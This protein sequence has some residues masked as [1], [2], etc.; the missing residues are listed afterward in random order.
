MPIRDFKAQA[1]QAR[2]NCL[3][4]LND[5]NRAYLLSFDKAY[6]VTEARKA[7]FYRH[8]PHF[9]ANVEDAKKAMQNAEEINALFHKLRSTL[10]T[11]YYATIINVTKRFVRWLNDGEL[12]NGFKQ[13][14]SV[15]KKKL[16]RQLTREDMIEWADGEAMANATASVQLKAILLTQLEGGFRPS[17]FIDLNYGDIKHEDDLL[18]AHVRAGKTGGRD[19]LLFKSAKLLTAWLN[20]HPTKKANDPLWIVENMDK[21]H[22]KDMD[23]NPYGIRRYR[24]EALKK[25]IKHL[26]KKAGIRKPLDFYNFRHSA[27]F[28]AKC[29]NMPV[30][31]AATNFGH[32]AQYFVETYGRLDVNDRLNRKRKHLGITP[33]KA[34]EKPKRVCYRCKYI[35]Q[36]DMDA[37][38][39]CDAPLSFNRAVTEEKK[40][41]EEMRLVAREL[42]EEM[43]QSF[44]KGR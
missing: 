43:R 30:D 40:R 32:S 10:G 6:D 22:R 14:R 21:S 4:K 26:A 12:P 44:E 33:K 18:V 28:L 16:K 1:E 17:E 23:D 25:R 15:P 38:A 31:E 7:I 41:R 8:I 3:G 20:A 2:E 11:A 42:L 5:T 19:V 35:N 39:Q 9:L 27:C 34:K 37:C 36:P 29:D 24:Y 13:L